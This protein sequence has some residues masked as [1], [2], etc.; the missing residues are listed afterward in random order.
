MLMKKCS[1]R[2]CHKIVQ[3]GVKYCDKHK[4]EDRKKYREYKEKRMRDE[5]EAKRQQFYNSEAWINL[6]AHV[7][8]RQL[9]IDILEYYETGRIVQAEVYHHIEEITEAWEKR[10][11]EDNIFGL[12]QS[13]HMRVHSEYN[14]DYVSKRRMQIYLKNL[15]QKFYKEFDL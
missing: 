10:L 3:D 13:N 8:A 1:H 2:G 4:A 7:A 9:C 11:D 14:K 6:H 15:M 5:N 12:T